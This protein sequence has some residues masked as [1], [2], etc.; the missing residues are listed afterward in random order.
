MRR[1]EFAVRD[2]T[3]ERCEAR[4]REALE[5]LPGALAVD[6]VRIPDDQAYVSFESAGPIDPATI[7]RAIEQQSAGTEHDYRVR[8]PSTSPDRPGS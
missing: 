2:V 7:E 8:W 3:C 1:C 4:I 6:M 5:A